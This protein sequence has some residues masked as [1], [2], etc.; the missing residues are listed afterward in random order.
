MQRRK[1]VLNSLVHTNIFCNKEKGLEILEKLGL[2]SNIRPEKLKL[3][4][5]A[6]MTGLI[7]K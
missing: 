5:Y 2:D 1:T 4:D 7:L 3:E 6:N